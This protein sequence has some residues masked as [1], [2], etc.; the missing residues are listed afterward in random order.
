[1]AIT[2]R[3]NK[4]SDS[5]DRFSEFVRCQDFVFRVSDVDG[6]SHQSFPD[7]PPVTVVNFKSFTQSIA[8]PEQRLFHFLI[9]KIKPHESD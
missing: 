7:A 6:F 4:P 3:H 1:M 8:D 9:G 5:N 2:S